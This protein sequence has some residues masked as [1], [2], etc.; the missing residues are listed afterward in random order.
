MAAIKIAYVGGGSTRAPGTVAAYIMH[1]AAFTGTTMTLI[2]PNREGLD[3]T[4][5]IAEKMAAQR[6]VDLTI[7]T[8]T[9]LE[10]GLTDADAVLSSFRPGG[11]TARYLD[12]S[13]PLKYGV[14]GQETQ[15]PGGFF[16][17]LRSV[18]V[19]KELVDV[20]ARVAPHATLFNYTNPV[21][22]VAQA[23]SLYTAV[24]VISLCEGPIVFPEEIAAG[25]G[26]EPGKMD[27]VMV[28][29][30]HACF[31]VR[32]EYDGLPA[33]PVLERAL[34]RLLREGSSDRE[35]VRRLDMAVTLG[36]IPASYMKYYYY[37]DEILDELR[38]K[39]TTRAQD[40]MAA[41]PDYLQHYREQAEAE[42]P[43]LEPERARG[44]IF[45]LELAVNVMDSVYNDKREVWTLNVPN[46]GAL[47]GMPD[48]RI[49]EVPCVVS[50]NAVTPLVVGELPRAVRG[51]V[52]A[53]GEYQDLAARAAW[54]EDRK[55]GVQAL[56]SNPLVPSL[57]LA[58]EIYA[59]MAGAHAP[60][61]TEGLR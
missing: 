4:K 55:L 56:A 26:L 36:S 47:K 19:I 58:K 17:A 43:R 46:G 21:N 1:G 41:V 39:P 34:E 59:E 6:G 29:L 7:E 48:D 25:A 61:L 11:F 16:M 30:N 40:I 49:V 57:P 60:Y 20:M 24:P 9:D 22:I 18:K 51:L 35:T 2:D 28:G 13:I 12:E 33:L 32:Q 27:A 8:T 50:R 44:G 52:G 10:A 54:E 42:S 37:R 23:V 45:E 53:L 14:I 5:R 15:G 38:A 3:L 31:S